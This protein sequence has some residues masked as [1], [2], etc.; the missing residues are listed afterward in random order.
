MAQHLNIETSVV[1]FLKSQG[2]PS[3]F[4][5]RQRL[6]EES[7]LGDAFGDFRGTAE[8]NVALLRRLQ[9][10]PTQPPP[11]TPAPP[12]PTL[13]TLPPLQ[14]PPTTRD[15]I[16]QTTPS[17]VSNVLDLPEVKEATADVSGALSRAAVSIPRGVEE[18]KV[19]AEATKA[20]ATAKGEQLTEEL[21]GQFEAA[22]LFRSGKRELGEAQIAQQVAQK[23]AEAETKLGSDLYNLFSKEEQQFGSK[24]IADLSIPEAQE[25]AK[26]PAPVRGAVMV[27]YENAITK[28][29]EK[30]AGQA[31]K[32]LGA[33]GYVLLPD[34]TIV[35]KPSE[36]RA[37]AREER[38]IR[39][40]E[41]TE[42]RLELSEE[43]A[44]RAEEAA[45]RAEERFRIEQ[46]QGTKAERT[47]RVFDDLRVSAFQ[48]LEQS[49]GS[50]G[51]VSSEV[52]ESF[53]NQVKKSTPTK[54]EDFDKEFGL[55]LN[56]ADAIRLG[57]NQAALREKN[58]LE[59]LLNSL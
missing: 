52:F 17:T 3:D 6:F 32:T 19:G 21:R 16:D 30:A 27:A 39:A 12:P 56:P 41:R 35:Q 31:E 36:A 57:V 5:S 44:K 25:F 13:P 28:A 49:K 58:K 15:V 46:I 50:D 9:A 1:D 10:T 51:Y 29:Q 38:S 23:Q 11:T 53:R 2:K 54:I 43:S 33:L 4:T 47:A 7:G 37:E 55:S 48:E 26:I 45:R 22:G 14:P 59:A 42:R 34:G 8:Q 20:A 40:E 24:F 18:L